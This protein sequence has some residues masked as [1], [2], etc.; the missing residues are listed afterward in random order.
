VY[1]EDGPDAVPNFAMVQVV[2]CL[3]REGATWFVTDGSEPIRTRDPDASAGDFLEL[4]QGMPLGTNTFELMYVF[5]S[6]D[7]YA[8]HRVEAKGFLIRRAEVN[9]TDAINVTVV[10]SLSPECA[11]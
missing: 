10:A 9:A 4:T 11:P 5:P 3:S 1:G 7:P 8:G 6:P 2:G